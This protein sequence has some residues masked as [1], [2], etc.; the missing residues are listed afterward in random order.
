[1]RARILTL[2]LLLSASLNA[3]AEKPPIV[4]YLAGDSTLAQKTL[5]KRPETGWGEYLQS[6]FGSAQIRIENRA[7]N[8]RSTKSFIDEGRWQAIIEQLRK[9]DYVFIEFGHNDEKSE[10]PKRYAAARTDYRNNLIRF[11]TEVRGKNAF[12]VLL[13][14]VVRRRFN[15]MGEFIDTHGEY[16]AVVREVAAEYKVP[17]IDMQRKSEALV[18]HLGIED[19]KK[20]FLI[21]KAAEHPNYPDG[22]ED[23]THFS[24]FGAE[25]MARLA[26]EGIRETR[27]ELANYLL[28]DDGENFHSLL[29]P[30]PLNGG[31]RLDGYWV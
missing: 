10:D 31:F 14:P 9:G 8:G 25:Q 20:L 19:S 30:A 18:R 11:V 27:T 12:P 13:T 28:K 7:Q 15:A 6:Q 2:V 1:M 3:V 4:V 22:V 21:L 23:N 17:L 29:M 26:A 24:P 16:P 5:D